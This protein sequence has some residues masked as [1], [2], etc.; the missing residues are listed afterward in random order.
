MS[1]KLALREENVMDT[2][3]IKAIREALN[4]SQDDLAKILGVTKTSVSRYEQ[5]QAKPVESSE[6]KL[7]FLQQALEDPEHRETLLNMCKNKQTGLPAA[8][9]VLAFIS[10]L[11]I[12]PL[13]LM[14]LTLFGI[15]KAPIG[16]S[17]A[18]I[19]SK[20][21]GNKPDRQ[22]DSQENKSGKK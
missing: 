20:M 12:M 2:T 21:A 1:G 5:G 15:M 4:L 10:A 19:V 11:P 8:A 3:E 6:K 18:D 7:L 22:S 13:P 17:F 9:G 14:G 16:K